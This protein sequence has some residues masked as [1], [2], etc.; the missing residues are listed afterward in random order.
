[1]LFRSTNSFAE[2][3][4]NEVL[5]VEMTVEAGAGDV[6]LNGHMAALTICKA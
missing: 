4:K 3:I 2:Y 6:D 5:A 1:M